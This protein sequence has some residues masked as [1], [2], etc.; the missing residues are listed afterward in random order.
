M[1]APTVVHRPFIVSRPIEDGEIVH[2]IVGAS[3]DITYAW[4]CSVLCGEV[5]EELIGRGRHRRFVRSSVLATGTRGL[6]AGR[7]TCEACKA[8]AEADKE[9]IPLL[10][11]AVGWA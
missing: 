9:G 11:G 8:A 5:G 7:V 10:C 4:L 6:K 1:K 2:C 3:D